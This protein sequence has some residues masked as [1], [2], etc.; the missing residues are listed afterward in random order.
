ME[1]RRPI[2]DGENVTTLLLPDIHKMY[3]IEFDN[4]STTAD[5]DI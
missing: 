5:F 3:S 1:Q 2:R 4:R